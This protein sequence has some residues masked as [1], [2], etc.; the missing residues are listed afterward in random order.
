[1]GHLDQLDGRRQVGVEEKN[2]GVVYLTSV[3]V[4]DVFHPG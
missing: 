4:V 3:C 1:M 2:F